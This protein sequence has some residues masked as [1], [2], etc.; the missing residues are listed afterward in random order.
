M[1]SGGVCRTV[2][3]PHP[4]VLSQTGM[5]AGR[6]RNVITPC[7]AE[8]PIGRDFATPGNGIHARDESRSDCEA[9]RTARA[10][11]DGEEGV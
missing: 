3:P 6:T 9:W 1:G 7:E 10:A 8:V 2:P 11:V 5:R 4:Q